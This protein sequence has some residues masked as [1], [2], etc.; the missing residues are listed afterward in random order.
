MTARPKG[1]GAPLAAPALRALLR[2][3]PLFSGCSTREIGRVA[4]VVSEARFP[5]GTVL[6][7][8][9]RAGSLAFL[10]VEG[11][12]AVTT[13]GLVIAT[14]G[15]GDLFGELSLIDGR[16][17]SATVQAV[18]DVH[19]LEIDGPGFRRILRGA[20]E[21]VRSLLGTLA[22]RIRAMDLEGGPRQP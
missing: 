2:E 8:E 16:P 11:S 1:A 12:V 17:R 7:R 9:G 18:S 13:A 10:M 14:L 19:V 15:P 22:G 4:A 5:S 20:P 3:V 21:L 6:T